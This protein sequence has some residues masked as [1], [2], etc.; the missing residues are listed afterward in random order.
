MVFEEI[1][2]IISDLLN[3]DEDQLT[4]E[5]DIQNELS[6]DSLD[7]YEILMSAEDT[8]NVKVEAEDVE[9]IHTIGDAVR[10]IEKYLDRE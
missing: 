4:E 9:E 8:F 1:K 7:L 10:V 6:A 2:R 5:T 3:V